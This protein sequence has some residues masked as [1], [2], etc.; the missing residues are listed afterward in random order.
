MNI[1]VRLLNGIQ[2][3]ELKQAPKNKI[4]QPTQTS[5]GFKKQR[6]K[7]LTYVLCQLSLH[8]P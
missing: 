5:Y 1:S 4:S 2:T 6:N 7:N 3:W 8:F